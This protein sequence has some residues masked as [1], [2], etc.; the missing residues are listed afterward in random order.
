MK[1]SLA[2]VL[3]ILGALAAGILVQV[4]AAMTVMI[5]AMV[6]LKTKEIPIGLTVLVTHIFILLCFGAWYILVCCPGMKA[7]ISFKHT[8]R[9]KNVVIIALLAVGGCFF[10]NFVMPIATVFIPESIVQAYL[11]LM[12]TAGFGESILPTIAAVLIAPFGEELLFRGVVY[13]YASNMVRDMQDRRRAFY[14]ANVVQALAFG[15][16]HGN[17]IQ[18]VYAFGLGLL[19]G[20]MRERF[21]SVWASAAGHIIINGC[22]AFLWE[23]LALCMPDSL[24]VY[25]VAAAVSFSIMWIGF[26][27]GGP[28]R[29]Y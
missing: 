28:A 8:F 20:Y 23:P 21:G 17:L 10:T 18:G 3:L 15:I 6:F 14:L 25:A 19:L 12:E 27:K 29:A 7:G 13:H 5:P 24:L 4:I 9:G 2:N 11:E 26:K 22:S 16:F 1:K